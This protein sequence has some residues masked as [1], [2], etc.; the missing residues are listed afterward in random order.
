[1]SY[2]IDMGML[3]HKGSSGFSWKDNMDTGGND[4]Y[5]KKIRHKG[6]SN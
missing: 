1:M 6:F 3:R 5:G 2:I 4:T